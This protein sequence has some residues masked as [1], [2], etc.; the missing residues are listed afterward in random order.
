MMR[1]DGVNEYLGNFTEGSALFSEIDDN[2]A[3]TVLGFLHSLLDTKD[4]CVQSK[5]SARPDT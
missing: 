4:H 1:E 3:A 5:R 2:T